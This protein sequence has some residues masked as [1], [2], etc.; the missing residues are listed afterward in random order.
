[1]LVRIRR[2]G[3]ERTVRIAKRKAQGLAGREVG[4]VAETHHR[5]NLEAAETRRAEFHRIVERHHAR[6]SE[7]VDIAWV[8]RVPAGRQI[9]RAQRT[10]HVEA[11]RR[12]M[13]ERH[14]ADRVRTQADKRLAIE[15]HAGF[16]ERAGVR[17]EAVFQLE[18]CFQAAAQIFHALQAP[19]V[20]L[21]VALFFHPLRMA[22]YIA[23]IRDTGI[24]AAV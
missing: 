17:I 2:A 23:D 9:G 8:E 5:A 13:T 1:V 12:L 6:V 3:L 15:Q 24:Q 20:R 22:A 14:R 18:D 16:S 21:H 7:F 4:R 10:Q 11:E 19:A